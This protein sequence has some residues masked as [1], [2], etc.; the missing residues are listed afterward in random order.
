M[1]EIVGIVGMQELVQG[2]R[3]ASYHIYIIVAILHL[4][5]K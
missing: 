3:N 5:T 2:A 4:I 1:Q